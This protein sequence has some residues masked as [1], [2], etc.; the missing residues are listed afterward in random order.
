MNMD[1]IKIMIINDSMAIRLYLEEVVNSFED[2]KVINSSSNGK[3]AL[4]HLKRLKPDIILL[5]LEMPQID[6]LTF[7][8]KIR[9]TYNIPVIVMSVYAND[10]SAVLDDAIK[11]GAVDY[12]APPTDYSELQKRK[13]K[14]TLRS[15]ISKAKLLKLKSEA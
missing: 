5:D 6:G 10:G 9:G 7:L 1:E 12:I 14:T 2:C 4:I 8:E 11:A 15:K 13:F 3:I